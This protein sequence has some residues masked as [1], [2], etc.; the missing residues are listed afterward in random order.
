MKNPHIFSS[1]LTVKNDW[2][3]GKVLW[4]KE[5][6]EWCPSSISRLDSMTGN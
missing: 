5:T 6:M 3:R 2:G 4:L 1:S